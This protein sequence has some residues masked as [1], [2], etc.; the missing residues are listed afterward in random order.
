MEAFRLAIVGAG[1][2]GIVDAISVCKVLKGEHVVIDIYDPGL[3]FRGRSFNTGSERMLLNTSV[4][5]SFIDP[6]EPDGFERFLVHD[7]GLHV[8]T[9]DVVPRDL[10]SAFLEKELSV[11]RTYISGVNFISDRVYD[12]YV[13]TKGG[14]PC[15]HVNEEITDYDAVI[16]STGLQFKKDVGFLQGEK[17]LP[18]YPAKNLTDMDRRASVLILGS[19]LSAVDTLAHLAGCEHEGRIDICSTSQLFPSVRKQVIKPTERSFLNHYLMRSGKLPNDYSLISCMLDMLDQHFLEHGMYLTD[20]IAPG[21]RDSVA[22][23]NYEI[24]LCNQKQNVW[25]DILM[26]VIDGLNTVWPRLSLDDKKR[27]N[28]EVNSWLGRIAHS[29]P[30]RNARTISELFSS[31]QL[32]MINVDDLSTINTDNYDVIINTTGL[33]TADT[34]SLLSHLAGKQLL[35]FNGLGGVS[36][37]TNNHRLRE[38][39][40]IY[41]NGSIVQG[42]VF[43]AN[44]VYSTS[45]GAQKIAADINRVFDEYHR[46]ANVFQD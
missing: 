35:Q 28:I 23:L 1:P 21:D 25:E 9:G 4:G 10:A 45:Y 7:Q 34:D 14:K 37:N 40:P 42:E 22:Q 29:M 5:V 39:L 16:I 43:T 27:F 36:I 8:S 17:I 12:L 38:D 2:S 41:A 6:E 31:G 15:I 26:D 19:K 11:A 20:F 33:Q 44:S 13:N 18:P 3:P 24:Q 30:L 46:L 32:S